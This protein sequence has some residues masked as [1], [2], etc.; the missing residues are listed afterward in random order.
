MSV[1]TKKLL[2]IVGTHI[3]INHVYTTVKSK[4][5]K[6]LIKYTRLC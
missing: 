3:K 6:K 5:L 4:I 1:S 2:E